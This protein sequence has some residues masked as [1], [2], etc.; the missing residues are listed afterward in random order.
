MMVPRAAARRLA[1]VT[2]HVT[3]VTSPDDAPAAATPSQSLPLW[4]GGAPCSSD[5]EQF[6]PSLDVCLHPAAAAG[7]ELGAVLIMPGGGY[8]GRATDHEGYQVAAAVIGAG[9]HAFILQYR[10]SPNVH[11][12]PL[13][14]ASRGLR[15][16]RSRAKEWGVNSSHIAVCGFSAGGH[17]AASLSVLHSRFPFKLED[18]LHAHSNRPDATILAYPVITSSE[19]YMHAGSFK[20]LLGADATVRSLPLSL[21]A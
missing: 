8:G 11:P 1:S 4:P 18:D 5:G 12:A 9:F 20:N 10:V 19:P 7:A 2:S 17:L 16:I 3:A 21:L 15:L 13:L 14:D 6:Q